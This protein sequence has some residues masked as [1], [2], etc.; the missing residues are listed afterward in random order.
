M[1][2]FFG[3]LVDTVT[4][5]PGKI[6]DIAE[7]IERVADRTGLD[8][9]AR[10]ARRAGRLA[11]LAGIAPT[12]ILVAGQKIIEG[13]RWA[14]GDGDPEW[15]EGF[16]NGSRAFKAELPTLAA[17]GSAPGWDG[18][19]APRAYRRRAAEQENRV[20]TLADADGQIAAVIGREADEI[21]ET[22]RIL[23]NLHQW[24]ADYGSYT[25]AL[26]V[27]PGVGK[28]L[29]MEA[30]TL[31]VQMALEE[32]GKK[33]WQMHAD[34]NANAADVRGVV[35][36]Y[37]QVRAAAVPQDSIGDFDP[38]A[39]PPGAQPRVI[40][41]AAIRGLAAVQDSAGRAI[42]AAGLSVQGVGDNMSA[43][44]GM[45]CAVTNDAVKAAQRERSGAVRGAADVCDELA[46]KLRHAAD[47]YDRADAEAKARLDDQL[48]PR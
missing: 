42:T 40:D 11:G 2:E 31:A 12:P 5:I 35:D 43:T 29:Q 16:H 17:A 9:L 10:Q 22:R 45:I 30:E 18:G 19:P 6:E 7:R 15:G 32:A 20:A 33:M 28:Y 39:S 46:A 47:A 41:A 4:D 1:S 24:L 37:R 26:G 8:D 3:D 23:E 34:A 13:M 38:P 44:H 27:I 48:P 25:Q 21:N 14:S 36:M